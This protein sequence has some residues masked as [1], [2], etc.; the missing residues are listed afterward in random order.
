M[1]APELT[2]G[3]GTA[4]ASRTVRKSAWPKAGRAAA[5]AAG[6]A[7]VVSRA[8]NSRKL[9]IAAHAVRRQRH[10]VAMA[11]AWPVA[12]AQAIF[13][14]RGTATEGGFHADQ[15]HSALGWIGYF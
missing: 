6:C 3:G 9:S 13:V 11:V 7:C 12:S 8:P 10:A 5:S 2:Y 14:R 4:G 1:A 15:Q